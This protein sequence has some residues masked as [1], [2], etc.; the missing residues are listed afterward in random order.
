MDVHS[1][2]GLREIRD[3]DRNCDH[4]GQTGGADRFRE[5]IQHVL[6]RRGTDRIDHRVWTKRRQHSRDVH[7]QRQGRR[8]LYFGRTDIHRRGHIHRL[9]QG[10]SR[11]PRTSYRYV[12]RDHRPA[13]DQPFLCFVNL[14]DLRR[15]CRCHAHCGQADVPQQNGED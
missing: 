14:Q 1:G 15:Q 10:G 13:A 11:E 2:C 7:L 4:Q 6:H 5:S 3:R 12:H 9:L 8:Q